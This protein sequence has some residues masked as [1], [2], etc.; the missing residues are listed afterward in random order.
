MKKLLNASLLVAGTAI[1]AGLIALPLMAVNLG[2]GLSAAVIALMVFIAY[3]ASMMTLDLNERCGQAA[4]IVEL[5][6]C[7]S[8]RKAYALCFLSFYALSLSLLTA[9]FS[10][11]TDSLHVFLGISSHAVLALCAVGLFAILCLNLEIFSRLNAALVVTL[12]GAIAVAL[13]KIHVSSSVSFPKAQTSFSEV[14]AF[15]PIIFTS[16][17]VQNICP[18]VFEYLNK[19]RAQINKAF[20]MGITIPALVYMAW[21][22]FV[23]ENILANDP[24]FFVRLQQHQV[25][26]GELIKFLC[27]SSNSSLLEGVLKVLSL[28][29]IVTSAIGIALGL[30]K[31]VREVL[32]PS[33]PLA[34]MILCSVPV[35]L[36]LSVPNAF[37]PV[38]SFGGMIATVFVLFIPAYLERKTAHETT[39]KRTYRFCVLFG[40]LVVLCELFGKLF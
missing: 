8:G 32:L 5:S 38:L 11:I 1:G 7:F 22:F 17:G 21:I 2:I 15:L 23:F 16:F 20:L 19:D 3:Q 27:E 14:C 24:T 6:R 13:F 39:P 4:S 10:G 40:V 30:L 28:S 26:A 29:A 34:S 36:V 25:S 12:L 33:R 35:L 18:V 37:I 31:S 9:Y